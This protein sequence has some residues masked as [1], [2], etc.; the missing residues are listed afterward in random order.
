MNAMKFTG[1]A[2]AVCFA[3]GLAAAV[4]SSCGK[5]ETND[6]APTGQTAGQTAAPETQTQPAADASQPAS[7]ASPSAQVADAD[8]QFDMKPATEAEI[9]ELLY[10][11]PDPVATIDGARVAS[12]ICADRWKV[13]NPASGCLPVRVQV[14]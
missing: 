7:S 11:L 2:I 8:M 9:L 13:K 14:A 6:P 1:K 3:A 10:F 4:F 12:S 5:K